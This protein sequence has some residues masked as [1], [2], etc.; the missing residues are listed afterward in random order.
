MLK[1][2]WDRLPQQYQQQQQT[3][4]PISKSD[5]NHPRKRS[6]GESLSSGGEAGHSHQL[7]GIRVSHT[8]GQGAGPSKGLGRPRQQVTCFGCGKQGH[9]KNECPEGWARVFRIASPSPEISTYKKKVHF[10]G[11]N[12]NMQLD[13]GADKTAVLGNWSGPISVQVNIQISSQ[14]GVSLKCFP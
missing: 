5:D 13:T 9:Y 6:E 3:T 12:C 2:I 8:P 14:L 10:N 4:R 11:L 1:K 7:G